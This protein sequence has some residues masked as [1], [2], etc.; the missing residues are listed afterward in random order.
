MSL[1]KP[2]CLG[3]QAPAALGVLGTCCSWAS[4]SAQPWPSGAP[5]GLFPTAEVLS[6][7]SSRCWIGLGVSAIV[8]QHRGYPGAGCG[9]VWAG[10]GC[11]GSLFPPCLISEKDIE[12][13]GLACA[14]QVPGEAGKVYAKAVPSVAVPTSLWLRSWQVAYHSGLGQHIQVLL[15][16][17]GCQ[18]CSVSAAGATESIC[19]SGLLPGEADLGVFS[20]DLCNRASRGCAGRPRYMRVKVLS[21]HGGASTYPS[22]KASNSLYL[23]APTL[24]HLPPCLWIWLFVL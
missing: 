19:C 15:A 10:V 21:L 7:T 22:L 9:C 14:L 1:S 5:Q 2:A 8:T 23:G 13:R 11:G 24:W 16:E 20:K 18:F 3:S 17:M 6:Q 4:N 12:A